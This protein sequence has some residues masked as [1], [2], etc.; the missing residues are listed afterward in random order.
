MKINI[1]EIAETL[2][3]ENVSNYVEQISSLQLILKD[4]WY[5]DKN[6]IDRVNYCE[7]LDTEEFLVLDTVKTEE[8]IQVKFE[9]PFVLYCWQDEKQLLRVSA[10]ISGCCEIPDEKHFNYDE[11]DFGDMNRNE[12]LSYGDMVRIF[13]VEYSGI[14]AGQI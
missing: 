9:M 12:L 11:L 3:W 8:H 6:L 4:C 10:M 1:E 5:I 7:V 14:E 2:L 13:D